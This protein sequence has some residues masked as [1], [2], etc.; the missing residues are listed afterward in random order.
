M[1]AHPLQQ[2]FRYLLAPLFPSGPDLAI[3][4][5]DHDELKYRIDWRTPTDD[6]PSKHS[7]P[8]EVHLTSEMLDD[9]S[10]ASSDAF[11]RSADRRIE[12]HVRIRLAAFDPDHDVPAQIPVPAETWI[13]G[14]DLIS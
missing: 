1:N 12:Q 11:R 14:T 2:H 7:R 5:T 8:I 13:I 6:R 4:P 9:Y 10:D 3:V